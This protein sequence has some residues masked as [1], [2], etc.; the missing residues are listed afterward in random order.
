M[1]EPSTAYSNG[2]AISDAEFPQSFADILQRLEAIV[3]LLAILLVQS[4]GIGLLAGVG[5][6]FVLL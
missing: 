5:A 2:L 4:G 3:F 6:I 1:V